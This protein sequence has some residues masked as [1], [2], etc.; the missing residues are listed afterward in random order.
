MSFVKLT[1]DTAYPT[2]VEGADDL[3]LEP[4]DGIEQFRFS[5]TENLE[6]YSLSN[7]AFEHIQ[8]VFDGELD[9]PGTIEEINAVGVAEFGEQDCHYDEERGLTVSGI[10]IYLEVK[11]QDD[12]EIDEDALEDIFHIIVLSIQVDDKEMS[13]SEF[14]GYHV[15]MVDEIPSNLKKLN[16]SFATR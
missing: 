10:E 1:I 14:E 6:S 11:A 8:I 4:G 3:I 13:F 9:D 12:G 16:Q 15:S 2:M 5:G 7:W